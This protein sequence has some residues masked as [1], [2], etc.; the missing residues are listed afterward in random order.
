MKV[1]NE[2][3]KE[4]GVDNKNVIYLYNK[5]DQ[6]VDNFKPFV[7]NDELLTCLNDDEDFED[8][9]KLIDSKLSSFYVEVSMLIPYENASDYYEI[10]NNE[11]II[12][13]KETEF[14]YDCIVKIS[15][16]NYKKYSK[17]LMLK[18]DLDE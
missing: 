16:S 8:I 17:Y 15:K 18:K 3:L 5:Y 14:G 9:I 4:I 1:T 11:A 6:L 7:G 10:K 13:T 12:E 2:T